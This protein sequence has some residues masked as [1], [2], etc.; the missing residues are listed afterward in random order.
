MQIA[1]FLRRIV[2]SPAACL[3]VPQKAR[4]SEGKNYFFKSNEESDL[5]FQLD[6]IFSFFH[7][8]QTCGVPNLLRNAGPSSRIKR[9]DR[10][11]GRSPTSCAKVQNARDYT[12]CPSYI[13]VARCA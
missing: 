3:A 6:E 7:G 10:D 5:N 1:S 4:F 9:P 8:V 13:F 2:F 11:A 12:C